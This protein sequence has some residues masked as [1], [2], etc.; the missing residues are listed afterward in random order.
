MR[1]LEQALQERARVAAQLEPLSEESIA[2][3]HGRLAE[4]D[5]EIERWFTAR[6]DVLK[7]LLPPDAVD[8]LIA[9]IE[10]VR[11]QRAAE[12]EAARQ[13]PPEPLEETRP[14]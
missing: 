5:R 11:Q 3:I 8:G 14:S 4:L 2:R 1:T 12:E 13:P 6:A 7:E 9:G 10:V